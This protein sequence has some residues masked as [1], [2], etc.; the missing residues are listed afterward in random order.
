MRLWSFRNLICMTILFV[1][2]PRISAIDLRPTHVSCQSGGGMGA[3]SVGTGWKYGSHLRWET[4]LFIGFVPKYDSGSAKVSLALKE[5]FIPWH[6]QIKRNFSVEPLT[7]SL[8]FTTLISD[9]VWVHLPE[10]Y[11]HGYYI[12]PTK[13]RA[14][15]S[16]GQR[17]KWYLPHKR[18]RVESIS[19]YY[20]IGTCDIYVLSAAGNSEIKFHELLQLCIGV[21]INFNR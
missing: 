3:V 15:I 2:A 4:D 18:G 10:R 21:R 13:I 5:N 17:L 1:I 9:K 12:L 19:A 14:N 16:L 20:E 11:S 6:I 8:Y 7:A